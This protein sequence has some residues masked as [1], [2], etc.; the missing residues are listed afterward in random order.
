MPE[1]PDA[2][3]ILA[4]LLILGIL[5]ASAAF[6]VRHLLKP[7]SGEDPPPGISA[8]P[9]GWINFG[10]LVCAMI[11]AVFL[12]QNSAALFFQDALRNAENGLTPRLAILAVVTLQ[13]PMIA[14]FC[15][16]RRLYPH[17]FPGSLSDRRMTPAGAAR[18]TLPLF[19]RY[20]PIVWLT[21]FVWSALL[22]IAQ[23]LGW[24]DKIEPQ[25]LVRIFTSG[26]DFFALSF[27]VLF[28]IILAPVIEETI[29]RGGVY[30]FLKSQTTL[31]VAQ[32]LSG[33]LFALMH[34]NLMS[35]VPLVAVGILLARVYERS[36]NLLV[37]I[38]FHAAFNTV[39]LVLLAL[40]SQSTTVPS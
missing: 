12:V 6:W 21:A 29:F 5:A 13:I 40:L 20:L 14:V 8:W 32:L 24:L 3:A 7:E 18:E 27:L 38:F 4:S 23:S 17:L 28:A 30:R 31:P 2:F 37:P 16:A 26:D 19:F 34:A 22:E 36:G 15:G 35:F 33:A 39:S 9:V 10:V 11:T 1:Q 25:Q